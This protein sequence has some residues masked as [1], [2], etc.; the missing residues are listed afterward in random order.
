MT[1]NEKHDAWFAKEFPNTW[2]DFK[3]GE[4]TA[5]ILHAQS[6]VAWDAALDAAEGR[7]TVKWE[8]LTKPPKAEEGPFLVTNNPTAENAHGRPSHV[9]CVSGIY[10]EGGE[11]TAFADGNRQIHSLK[12]FARVPSLTLTAPS[13][14]IAEAARLIIAK[15]DAD[16]KTGLIYG[17]NEFAVMLRAL[18]GKGE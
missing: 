12:M 15:W 2:R 11:F 13:D 7:V 14:K 3:A 17:P 9:W 5:D 10:E 16:T 4:T 1:D 6:V 8:V 18:A